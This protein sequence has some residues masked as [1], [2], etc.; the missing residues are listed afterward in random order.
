MKKAYMASRKATEWSSFLEQ[1][2]E[3]YPRRRALQAELGKL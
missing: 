1:L 3:K 2:K